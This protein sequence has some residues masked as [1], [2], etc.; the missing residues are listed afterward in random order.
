MSTATIPAPA[1]TTENTLPE[2]KLPDEYHDCCKLKMAGIRINEIAKRKGI[3]RTTVRRRI[4]AVEQEAREHI[5]QEPAINIL[6]RE[7]QRQTDLEEQARQAALNTR[8]ERMK[9]AFLNTARRCATARTNL[10]LA[11]GILPKAPEQVFR[12]TADMKPTDV[13]AET[14]RRS[15]R[16]R[17]ELIEDVLRLMDALPIIGGCNQ[18]TSESS[19][20]NVAGPDSPQ[21]P[22]GA[23]LAAAQHQR[24]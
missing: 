16:S 21:Q 5:A 23:A 4:L 9:D 24:S 11:V 8:S 7:I 19:T 10:L 1:P 17:A 18:L 3:H 13:D 15:K 22:A 2:S 6:C 14:L 20:I 12:V